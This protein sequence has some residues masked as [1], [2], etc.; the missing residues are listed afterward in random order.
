MSLR[1]VC[2]VIS[3]FISDS[4]IIDNNVAIIITLSLLNCNKIPC[5]SSVYATKI[6][7]AQQKNNNRSKESSFKPIF[8]L[9]QVLL[10]IKAKGEKYFKELIKWQ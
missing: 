6:P 3:V 2:F 10:H 9:A 8:Q 1:V 4:Y 7:Y 5:C